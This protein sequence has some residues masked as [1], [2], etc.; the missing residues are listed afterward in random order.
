MS[1]RAGGKVAVRFPRFSIAEIMVIVALVAFDCAAPRLAGSQP[2]IRCLILGGLPMQ[3]VL[4]IG[5]LL[6]ISQRKRSEKPLDF[7]VGFEVGGGICLLIYVAACILATESLIVH[8][9]RTVT[10]VLN[11]LGVVPYSTA[12]Y[13]CRYGLAMAYLTAPQLM[14]AL[15]AG[16]IN[17]R[18][19]T[20]AMAT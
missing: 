15:V 13:V 6:T 7:L 2:A 1:D 16:W 14:A 5:R 19:S 3:S 20:K 18:W 4:A 9:T 8:L 11:S 12:D 10:P 17:Q